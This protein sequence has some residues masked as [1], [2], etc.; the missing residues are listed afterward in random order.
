MQV[1]PCQQGSNQATEKGSYHASCRH[2]SAA[3]STAKV[4]DYD[5][6]AKVLQYMCVVVGTGAEFFD[7]QIT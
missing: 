2:F 1:P 6:S 4:S 3:A 7:S 5:G